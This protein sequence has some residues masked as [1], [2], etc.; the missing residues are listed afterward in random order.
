[1]IRP[2]QVIRRALFDAASIGVSVSCIYVFALAVGMPVTL[3]RLLFSPAGALGAL[4][5]MTS[6]SGLFT[7][8]ALSTAFSF[9]NGAGD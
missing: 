5:L 1:M 8:A 4:M 7:C 2:T 3:P 6:L 9:G